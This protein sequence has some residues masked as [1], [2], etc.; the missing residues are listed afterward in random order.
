MRKPQA[1]P[2]PLRREMFATGDARALGVRSSRLRSRDLHHPFHGVHTLIPPSTVRELC[3]AFLLVMPDEAY[4][5]HQTAAVLL[6]IP[7]PPSIALDAVHVTVAYPRAAPRGRGVSGHSLGT[8]DGEIMD[9]L[10]V[11]SPALV[12]CQLA[13]VLEREDLVAAGDHLVG[14]RQRPALAGIDE[15]GDAADGLR[16]TQ[17]GSARAWALQR[18]RAGADSRPETLL[19]L[20]LERRGHRDLE[21][22]APTTVRGG[23]LVLH[24]DLSIPSSRIAFEYEG[25]GHRVDERQWHLDIER[26]ELLEA[27]GWRVVRVTARDLFHD[28]AAFL[29]RLD[30]F[31]PNVG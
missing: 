7:L 3:E 14:A 27:E 11:C 12:W 10:P 13:S 9:G 1:L 18:I 4:F 22:N 16:R 17:G 6:G 26:R 8:V 2:L 31:G 5:S 19:R 24:P 20:L 28:R 23:R 15:L 21:V 29:R 30:E 25:D